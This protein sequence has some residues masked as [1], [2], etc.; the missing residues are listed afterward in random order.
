MKHTYFDINLFQ[1]KVSLP[2]TSFTVN[3]RPDTVLYYN[4]LSQV[5][6]CYLPA[7]TGPCVSHA[8]SK[9][10]KNGLDLVEMLATKSDF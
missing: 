5:V 10:I 3:R 2:Q 9:S 6:L 4:R 8:I 7:R 1:I